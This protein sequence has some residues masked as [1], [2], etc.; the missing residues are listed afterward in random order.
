MDDLLRGRPRGR[1]QGQDDTRFT[2]PL[3]L[4]P[5]PEILCHADSRR[6]PVWQVHCPWV[7]GRIPTIMGPFASGKIHLAMTT[8]ARAPTQP[9]K[10][11]DQL[12]G[13]LYGRKRTAGLHGKGAAAR[14]TVHPCCATCQLPRLMRQQGSFRQAHRVTR[15]PWRAAVEGTGHESQCWCR[16]PRKLLLRTDV[17]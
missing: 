1:P 6:F 16:A 9:T 12:L 13:C 3:F 17:L 8:R 4:A 15:R 5:F 10:A 7:F 14:R 2:V 11:Y